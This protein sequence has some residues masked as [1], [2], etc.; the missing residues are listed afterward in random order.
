MK[1]LLSHCSCPTL[2]PPIVTP[3]S[4]ARCR[5]LE[6]GLLARADETAG[7][8]AALRDREVFELSESLAAL[9]TEDLPTLRTE[10]HRAERASQGFAKGA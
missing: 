4:G 2:P 10:V 5:D 6:T 7:L 9:R 1:T 8:V 3:V